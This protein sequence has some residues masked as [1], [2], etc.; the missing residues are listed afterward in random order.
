MH[1]VADML[2]RTDDFRSVNLNGSFIRRQKSLNTFYQ[3]G[4]SRS[5]PAD[6][7]QRFPG[8]YV[9]IDAV[10]HYFFAESLMK[11]SYL[12]FI[13]AHFYSPLILSGKEKFGNNVV[14]YQNQD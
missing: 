10:K 13:V 4:F 9:Q 5:G 8:F 12:D 2:V 11:I 7:N 1:A 14:E 6:N 3:N